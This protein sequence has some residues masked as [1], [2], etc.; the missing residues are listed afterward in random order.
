[1]EWYY[2]LEHEYGMLPWIHFAEFVNLRFS[3]PIRFNPLG[4]LK[5]LQ[6]T[7][8]VEE[9]QR[10]FLMLLCRCDSLS[11]DHQMSLF[12]AGLGE[13]M[14]SDVEMQKPNDLQAVMSLTR[15]FE[16]R[17]SAATSAN[18]AAPA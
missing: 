17:A 3:P 12:T 15:A 6:R 13:P 8:T 11:P 18:T 14:T 5:A 4:E 9:Y 10:Q 7:G 2:S 16:H 1:V